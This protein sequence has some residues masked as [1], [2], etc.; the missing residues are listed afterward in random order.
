MLDQ[1]DKS[2]GILSGEPLELPI[3]SPF[4]KYTEQLSHNEIEHFKKIRNNEGGLR[5]QLER[6]TMV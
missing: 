6:R 1:I 5:K 2:S 4:I 3:S